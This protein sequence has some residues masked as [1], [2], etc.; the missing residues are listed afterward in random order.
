MDIKKLVTFVNLVETKNFT[1]TAKAIHVTQPTVTHDINAIE[2]EIGVKLFNRNKRYV[3]VTKSG[4]VFYQK[5]R[6]LI[7]NYN[8]AVQEIQEKDKKERL[9]INF[10][11]SYNP[12]NDKYIPLWLSQ[13][14]KKF[15]QVKFVLV[16]L[17]RNELKQQLVSNNLDVMLTTGLEAEDL[18]NIKVYPIETEPFKVIVPRNNPLSK[19]SIIKLTDFQSEKLLF[20]DNR[21][22]ATDIINLQNK[23]IHL[24]K[25]LNIT[26]AA[27]ISS[28]N[29]LLKA[30]Q[31]LGLGL[32][33]IYPELDSSLAYVLLDWEP[34]VDLVAITQKNNAK[35]IVYQFIKFIQDFNF[36]FE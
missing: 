23:I 13:F 6:P 1:K 9:Q 18:N 4:E 16:N 28:L 26:Y 30:N 19:K 14:Q 36:D 24:N 11:Y 20:L 31:G 25:D 15:P 29:V 12:F 27:E 10:G 8:S 22:A 33:C 7:N 3:N 32:Y 21:W 34:Q 2:D 5:I 17:N 35:R